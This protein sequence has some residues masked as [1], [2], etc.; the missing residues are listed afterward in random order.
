M[1]LFL[2]AC[3]SLAANDSSE[4][5]QFVRKARALGLGMFL[6]VITAC[7]APLNV[8]S[9]TTAQGPQETT[10]TAVP[11]TSTVPSTN[12]AEPVETSTTSIEETP[13]RLIVGSGGVLGWWDGTWNRAEDAGSV[14]VAA[15]TTFQVVGPTGLLGTA[16]GSAPRPG[17]EIVEG[18][19]VIDLEPDPYVAYDPFA[20]KPLAVAAEWDLVPR[21]VDELPLESDV[22]SQIVADYLAS[23]GFV[24]PDPVLVQLFRVD[25][26]ADGADE[27]IIVADNHGGEFFQQGVYSIVLVRRVVDEAVETAVLH[28]SIVAEELGPDE[29]PFSVVARVAAIADLDDDGVMEISLDSAYYEGAGTEVWDY[30]DD[31]LGFVSVLLTGCGA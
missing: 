20:S 19:V 13:P 1:A 3:L 8:D 5:A 25:L 7:S 11:A 10:T 9:N 18:H 6:T 27:V 30:V 26:D 17:C 12:V 24:D 14:P 28:E 21:P 22:Y 16:V 23:R 4:R 15:G 2:A 31:D 29:I